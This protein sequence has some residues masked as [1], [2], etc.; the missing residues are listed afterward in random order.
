MFD[1]ISIIPSVFKTA[2]YGEG[3]SGRSLCE[4]EVRG[5][6]NELMTCFVVRD[7][8]GGAWAKSLWSNKTDSPNEVQKFIKALR[9]STRLSTF[10]S[11]KR[12]D[13]QNPSEWCDEALATHILD[14]L[15]GI[16]A[17]KAG[18]LANSNQPVVLE[19]SKRLQ[20]GSWWQ[21]SVNGG[22]RVIRT[23]ASYREALKTVLKHAN[24][25]ALMDPN[26]DPTA[27]PYREL[28]DLL[29]SAKRETSPQPSIEIHRVSYAGINRNPVG[30]DE[31]ASRFRK[32]LLIP[33]KDAGL[34]AEV[35]I[36]PEDHDR[37]ILTN[38]GGIHLGNGLSTSRNPNDF[39][40]WTRMTKGVCDD[41]QRKFDRGYKTPLHSFF[42]VK[43]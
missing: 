36:W 29:V 10:E 32:E 13:P 18:K 23:T 9:C 14:P 2:S 8:R 43:G 11:R 21:K 20:E 28:P 3:E 7:L 35:F 34:D 41:V 39:C 22:S 37:H 6:W 15:A 26:L 27:A 25:I 33:L 38:L 12:S 4:A 31:W 19:I 16:L 40:T 1:E 24:S 5:I 42:I 30:G 17:C